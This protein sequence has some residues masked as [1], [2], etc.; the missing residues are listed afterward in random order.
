MTDARVFF[1]HTMEA[2]FVHAVPPRGFPEL[3]R[4]YAQAGFDLSRPAL[5]AY[6]YDT[7]RACLRAQREV[8][9]AH[10]SDDEAAYLQG[11]HCAEAYFNRTIIGGPLKT[12]LRSLGAQKVLERTTR[13]LRTGNNFSESSFTLSGP[14]EGTLWVNDLLHDSPQYLVG[15]LTRT[16]QLLGAPLEAQ[17]A[18]VEAEGGRFSVKWG[19]GTTRT[20]PTERFTA[21]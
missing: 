17:P 16:M 19:Q 18:G 1:G 5:P 4:R 14:R 21:N 8:A 6:T 13:S 11:A 7:W 15:V 12:L 20:L 2:M 3:E 10:A 9:L